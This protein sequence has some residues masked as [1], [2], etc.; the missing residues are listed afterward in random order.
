LNEPW[1]EGTSLP[2][3]A[4][5]VGSTI[6]PATVGNPHIRAHAYEGQL[7]RIVLEEALRGFGVKSEVIVE[8]KLAAAVAARLSRRPRAIA[9]TLEQFGK[10]LG[11]PWRADEK[12]AAAAAWIAL[13][14]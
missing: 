14:V 12:A 10:T 6:D 5:V 9:A 2:R 1:F 7:F 3:A 4:I 13:A 11:R 8:K